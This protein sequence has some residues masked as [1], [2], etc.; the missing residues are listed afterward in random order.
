MTTSNVISEQPTAS[1][2][3]LKQTLSNTSG[4]PSGAPSNNLSDDGVGAMVYMHGQDAA[5]SASTESTAETVAPPAQ[6]SPTE[7]DSVIKEF[8]QKVSSISATSRFSLPSLHTR[9]RT[10]ASDFDYT[11][12]ILPLI[13]LTPTYTT[14]EFRTALLHA[15]CHV[16]KFTLFEEYL[17]SLC[18]NPTDAPTVLSLFGKTV[19]T[20]GQRAF[21]EGM[22]RYHETLTQEGVGAMVYTHNQLSAIPL[23]Q[24]PSTTSPTNPLTPSEVDKFLHP[25]LTQTTLNTFLTHAK[26]DVRTFTL[27]QLLASTETASPYTENEFRVALLHAGCK[28]TSYA[29]FNAYLTSFCGSVESAPRVLALFGETVQTV[30]QDAF[31]E[32]V[33]RYLVSL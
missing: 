2:E 33:E 9:A 11:T 17:T 30:G 20:L 5:I 18:G 22:D 15:G 8:M 32:G 21:T 13:L 6:L 31:L 27:S 25:L 24:N 23:P 10:D 12:H 26:T 4:V 28:V 1:T 3:I 14:N 19:H 16:E 7:V 29:S